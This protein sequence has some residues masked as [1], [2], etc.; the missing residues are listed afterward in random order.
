MTRTLKAPREHYSCFLYI[1]AV[2]LADILKPRRPNQERK[3]VSTVNKL[4]SVL[5]SFESAW[6][7]TYYALFHLPLDFLSE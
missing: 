3:I 1:K 2:A 7:A 6:I 5:T 4:I